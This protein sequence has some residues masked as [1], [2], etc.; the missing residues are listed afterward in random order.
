MTD[1]GTSNAS[2]ELVV[3]AESNEN[4]NPNLTWEQTSGLAV[5]QVMPLLNPSMSSYFFFQLLLL[6]NKEK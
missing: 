1:H 6:S 5:D 3:P 2:E 4:S